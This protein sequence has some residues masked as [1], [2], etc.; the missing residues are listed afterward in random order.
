MD[1]PGILAI[2]GSNEIRS[3]SFTAMMVTVRKL[4][5]LGAR[6]HIFD[7]SREEVPVF[8]VEGMQ[9][10]TTVIRELLSK[11]DEFP[12]MLWCSPLYHGSITGVFKNLI[13][14]FELS[15]KR[16]PPYLTGKIIGMICTAGGNQGLQGINTMHYIARALRAWSLPYSV[17]VG[18]AYRTFDAEGNILDQQVKIQLELLALELY[19]GLIGR[20]S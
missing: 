12:G 14:W 16:N 7:L 9:N 17:A 4:E 13:D 11:L 19:Q 10:P 18:N 3:S 20:N 1:K 15:G 5:E 8:N 6:V 2:H